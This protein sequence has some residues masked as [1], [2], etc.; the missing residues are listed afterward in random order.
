MGRQK[1]LVVNATLDD[2]EEVDVLDDDAS[3]SHGIDVR[4]DQ[5]LRSREIRVVRNAIR[6]LFL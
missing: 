2:F 5:F 4:V 3:A 6:D 1:L